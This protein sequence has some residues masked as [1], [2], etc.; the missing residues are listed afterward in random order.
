MIAD[1]GSIVAQQ[2]C[3]SLKIDSFRE[4]VYVVK[5]PE[6]SSEGPS[7]RAEEHRSIPKMHIVRTTCFPVSLHSVGNIVSAAS[8]LEASTKCSSQ[9]ALCRCA[10]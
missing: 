2:Q 1:R 8:R 9:G 3:F 7:Q 6:A 10:V 5:H 4:L